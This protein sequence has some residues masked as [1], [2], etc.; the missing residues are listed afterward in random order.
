MKIN[1]LDATEALLKDSIKKQKYIQVGS[2][3]EY[4]IGIAKN[5]LQNAVYDLESQGYK[6]AVLSIPQPNMPGKKT[7]IIVLA[8]PGTTTSE[9]YNNRDKIGFANAYLQ[10]DVDTGDMKFYTREAPQSIS[11]KRISVKYAED[12]GTD[13]DGLIELRRGVPDLTIPNGKSYAQVRIAVDGTHY[14][15]GM[16]VYSNDIPEGKD[17]VVNSN[18]KRGTP[19]LGPKDHSVLKPMKFKDDG[20]LDD[21]PFGADTV[22]RKFKDPKTGMLKNSAIEVVGSESSPHEEGEWQDWG[23]SLSAQFLSKQDPRVAKKQLDKSVKEKQQKLKEIESITNPIVKRKMLESFSETCDSDAVHL[24]AAKFPRQST[25]VLLPDAKI[26]ETEIYAPAYK[27]GEQVALIRYPHGGTFEIPKLTVNNYSHAK[28][29]Y[30]DIKDAVVINPK[31]ASILSGA[32]FDG[33]TVTVIPLAGTGIKTRKETKLTPDLASIRDFD[34]KRYKL[35][36][37]APRLT[38]KQKG[39]LMGEVTNLITD[40]Q[41]QGASSDKIARAVRASMVVIDAEKHH[42]DY[43]QA[44]KDERI[45][46][47]KA[48]YQPKIDGKAGTS[49]LI[50]RAKSEL[51]VPKRK[52]YTLSKKTIDENGDKNYEESSRKNDSYVQVK[53]KQPVKEVKVVDPITGKTRWGVYA[54]KKYDKAT[55]KYVWKDVSKETGYSENNGSET[56]ERE[57][58]EWRRKFKNE[59]LPSNAKDYKIVGAVDK[60]TKMAEAKDAREL[61]SGKNHTGTV[62]ERVYADYANEMKDLARTARKEYVQVRDTPHSATAA[63][64]YEKEV[65]SLK[66]K[67][68]KAQAEKPKEKKAMLL[69][70]S[71]I[72]AQKRSHPEMS[73]EE[74]KKYSARA[75]NSARNAVF[76]KGNKRYKVDITPEEWNA[77]QAGALNKSITKAIIDNADQHQVESYAIPHPTYTPTSSEAVRIRAMSKSGKYTLSEIADAVGVS[78]STVN[79]LLEQ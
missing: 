59:P 50:S 55:G 41:V 2:G 61:L 62:I 11:S 30:G 21:N 78:T 17:I 49:T 45:S 40:M 79:K 27:Q 9:L 56:R 28:T 75:L 51:D 54:K 70:T 14:I 6:R 12:G 22:Q 16:A 69:A 65:K 19:V 26:K 4:Q 53:Y 20:T 25:H 13:A 63:K 18:K 67:L 33:D 74:I 23:K 8:A 77:I 57:K 7:T 64:T 66:D 58:T 36:D 32:D 15:K 31:T 60:S 42:L 10:K 37:N 38:A 39:R 5:K 73:K 52:A 43:K 44:F 3:T 68:I 48:E 71:K 72:E 35:P 29:K 76:G 24:K 1:E 46:Q 47:L 34:P